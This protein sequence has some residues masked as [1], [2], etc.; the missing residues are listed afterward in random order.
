MTAAIILGATNEL[1]YGGS[2]PES[3]SPATFGQGLLAGIQ[4]YFG[5][6]IGQRRQAIG[7]DK[8]CRRWQ[9]G[10]KFGGAEHQAASATA[11]IWPS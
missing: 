9:P 7:P 11:F 6:D 10:Q 2:R 8:N 4:K 3:R 1:F 5:R